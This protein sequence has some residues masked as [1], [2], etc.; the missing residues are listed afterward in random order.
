MK[1]AIKRIA[2]KSNR[3]SQEMMGHMEVNL[4]LPIAELMRERYSRGVSC[5]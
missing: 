1:K 3:K 4:M 5:V 2:Q